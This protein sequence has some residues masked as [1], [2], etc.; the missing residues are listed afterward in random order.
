MPERLNADERTDMSAALA[1]Q[2][3]MR[4]IP[5]GVIQPSPPTTALDE[6]MVLQSLRGSHHTWGQNCE[7]LQTEWAQW[8]GNEHCIAVNSGTAV[9]HM[10]LAACGLA[11]GDEVITPA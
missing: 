4:A 7:A 10:S 8:N 2:G 5:E 3:G 1:I 9:L 6:Q 11:A